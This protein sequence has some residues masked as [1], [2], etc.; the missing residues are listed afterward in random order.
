[1]EFKWFH[2]VQSE[3]QRMVELLRMLKEV[4]KEKVGSEVVGTEE[5]CS[6]LVVA[7]SYEKVGEEGSGTSG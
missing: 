2:R 1:M 6:E 7:W 5:V 3:V 4:H